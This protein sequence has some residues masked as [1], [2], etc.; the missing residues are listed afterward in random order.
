MQIIVNGI[1]VGT[2]MQQVVLSSSDPAIG[3]IPL[4]N[5]GH[6]KS[7]TADQQSS[8]IICT[9]SAYNGKRFHR[10]IYHDWFGKITV[11]RYNGNM[12]AMIN[13]IMQQFQ[14][15]GAETYFSFFTAITNTDAGSNDQYTFIQAVI[16][17]HNLGDWTGT[18]E[19]DNTLS[20]RCQALLR[21]SAA[22]TQVSAQIVSP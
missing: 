5:L 18:A 2:E 8:Q 1:N 11:A 20:F 13:R 9:P 19:V 22:L 4:E 15:T 6:M 14:A 7:F 12:T 17:T 10:N 3:T 21:T 16:D